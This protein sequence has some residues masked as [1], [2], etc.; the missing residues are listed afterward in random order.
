MVDPQGS[1]DDIGHPAL[2]ALIQAAVAGVSSPPTG[3]LTAQLHGEDGLQAL[4]AAAAEASPGEGLIL[5]TH[6]SIPRTAPSLTAPVP[7]LPEV[8]MAQMDDPSEGLRELVGGSSRPSAGRSWV[9]N[10]VQRRLAPK[11]QPAEA[12]GRRSRGRRQAEALSGKMEGS[13]ALGAF[14]RIEPRPAEV[15][16]RNPALGEAARGGTL[17]VER[18]LIEQNLPPLLPARLMNHPVTPPSHHP[19]PP[20]P[21]P[22]TPLMGSASQY[23]PVS[24]FSI[25][26]ETGLTTSPSQ[27]HALPNPF[28]DAAEDIPRAP[29]ATSVSIQSHPA[30]QP[31][32]SPRDIPAPPSVLPG[33]PLQSPES[34]RRRRDA[35]RFSEPYGVGPGPLD[36]SISE[37]GSYRLPAKPDPPVLGSNAWHPRHLPDPRV[38]SNSHNMSQLVGSPYPPTSTSLYSAE[39]YRPPNLFSPP[40]AHQP[41]TPTRVRPI[42][43]TGNGF[44]EVRPI[45]LPFGADETLD[46][47]SASLDQAL[48]AVDR[49]SQIMATTQSPSRAITFAHYRQHQNH[50]TP[51]RRKSRAERYELDEY[52]MDGA[53]EGGPL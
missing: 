7:P 41:H 17:A 35:R 19:R 24:H 25:R 33:P 43:S 44:T 53:T 5:S 14:L 27:H 49:L 12:P 2:D 34:P 28:S 37:D 11:P 31:P 52:V 23:R 45:A 42:L 13:K 38:G 10:R 50:I 32:S 51:T 39:Q 20:H 9:L 21:P 3:P 18:R 46:P 4:A 15:Y 29:Q 47:A 48:H 1:A 26:R 8:A 30:N 22:R 40:A 36:H 16:G 6:P